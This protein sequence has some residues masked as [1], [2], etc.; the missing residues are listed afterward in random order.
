MNGNV[1]LEDMSHLEYQNWKKSFLEILVTFWEGKAFGGMSHWQEIL[2]LEEI[3]IWM[4]SGRNVAFGGNVKIY[5]VYRKCHFLNI[6]FGNKV[7]FGIIVT[8]GGNVACGRNV[9]LEYIIFEK[10]TDARVKKATHDRNAERRLLRG[11]KMDAASHIC[12]LT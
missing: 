1:S 4:K 10:K 9:T 11:R 5:Y 3:H 2:Y 7:T 6:T 8:F 12:V